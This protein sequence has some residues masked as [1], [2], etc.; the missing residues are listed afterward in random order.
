L[1]TYPQLETPPLELGPGAGEPG[2]VSVVV[3]TYNR[4][5]IIGRTIESVLAQSYR[6]VEVVVADDGSTDATREVVSRYGPEV[7]YLHQ[8]NAGVSRARNTGISAARGEF[9]ALL[10]S[11]DL[12]LPWKVAVQVQF[13]RSF[14]AIG[15]ACTDMTAVDADGNV[16]HPAYLR[17]FYG[18]FRRT[19]LERW[20]RPLGRLGD[21]GVEVPAEVAE[22]PMWGGDMF[23]AMLFGSMVHTSTVLLRRERLRQVGGFDETL[24]FSGEDYDFHWRTCRE[25]P[26][27]LLDAASILYRI[28]APDQLTSA[29]HLVHIAQNNL[30]T[31]ERRL[32]VDRA[33]LELPNSA[34][35][36]QVARANAWVGEEIL[37]AGEAAGASRYLARSL[38][39]RPYQPRL[40]GLLLFSLLPRPLFRA[41][42]RLKRALSGRR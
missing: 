26:V 37:L 40:A 28:D 9:V 19:R 3:P 18:A 10:D 13:L 34:L 15:M 33:R 4:A 1:R 8:Q 39:A 23:S 29:E 16:V 6:P 42:R 20:V 25:G 12:W 17:T 22:R 5:Y 38:A 31:L 36:A 2:L 30:V 7:R 35:R 27:G 24:R 41:T 11:D 21:L 32:R 14:P